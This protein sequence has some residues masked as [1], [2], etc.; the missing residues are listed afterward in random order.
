MDRAGW[1][2]SLSRKG[3]GVGSAGG[4]KHALRG[5]SLASFNAGAG[6]DGGVAEAWAAAAAAQPALQRRPSALQL[7]SA[8]AKAYLDSS[9]HGGSRRGAGASAALAAAQ[10]S[11]GALRGDDHSTRSVRQVADDSVRSAKRLAGIADASTGSSSTTSSASALAQQAAQAQAAQAQQQQQQKTQQQQ[12]VQAAPPVDLSEG[13]Q[14]GSPQRPSLLLPAARAAPPLPPGP[15]PASAREVPAHGRAPGAG[16]TLPGGSSRSGS[17]DLS[18]LRPH[19]VVQRRSLD[20][21]LLPGG[22]R[23][24]RVDN[25]GVAGLLQWWACPPPAAG[26][27]APLNRRPRSPPSIRPLTPQP[28]RPPAAAPGQTCRRCCASRRPAAAARAG[29]APP[30]APPRRAWSA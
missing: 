2:P 3:S 6:E 11:G 9:T 30:A 12:H 27:T 25:G 17:A 28:R 26:W 21:Q 23:W 18:G 4:S 10:G 8:A 24:V 15:A 1:S 13:R 14:H 5:R 22:E 29:R 19:R 20:N 7:L 16:A